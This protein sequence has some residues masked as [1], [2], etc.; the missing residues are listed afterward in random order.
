MGPFFEISAPNFPKCKLAAALSDPPRSTRCVCASLKERISHLVQVLVGA[1]VYEN[2]K[3]TYPE[4]N[5]ALSMWKMR[6]CQF[7]TAKDDKQ[8]PVSFWLHRRDPFESWDIHAYQFVAVKDGNFTFNSGKL[9]N[10][11]KK[12]ELRRMWYRLKI[13]EVCV[14]PRQGMCRGSWCT[15]SVA[16]RKAI[17]HQGNCRGLGHGDGAGTLMPR[18]DPD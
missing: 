15:G 12:I 16:C 8:R 11:A 6:S 9:E 17:C 3:A 1:Q 7:M 14:C 2:Q 10:Y 13:G 5:E 18:D 4:I